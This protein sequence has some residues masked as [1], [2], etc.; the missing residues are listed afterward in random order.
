MKSQPLVLVTK[1]LQYHRIVREKNSAV[2]NG[3]LVEKPYKV[4]HA[5]KSEG[6]LTPNQVEL[7]RKN[8]KELFDMHE[9]PND[10]DGADQLV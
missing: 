3:T 10:T 6:A 4:S 2:V 8:P 5:V 9:T 7:F 1:D